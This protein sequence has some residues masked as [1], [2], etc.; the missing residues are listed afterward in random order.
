MPLKRYYRITAGLLLVLLVSAAVFIWFLLT[1]QRRNE[2]FDT[3]EQHQEND[4]LENF[5]ERLFPRKVV[6][7]I[8]NDEAITNN[9]SSTPSMSLVSA[10]PDPSAELTEECMATLDALFTDKKIG[11]L[12]YLWITFKNQLTYGQVYFDPVG[13]RQ[14]VSEAL[15]NPECS[16]GD[17]DE[18]RWDLYEECHADAFARLFHF[19]R[20]CN[21]PSGYADRIDRW[22]LYLWEEQES[23]ELRNQFD[24]RFLAIENA[25]STEQDRLTLQ[26]WEE[27]L[28]IRWVVER[29]EQF[30]VK[31][32]LIDPARDIEIFNKLRAANTKAFV[33]DRH[34]QRM[35]VGE[36]LQVFAARFGEAWAVIT[37]DGTS[38]WHTFRA[39]QYPWIYT[40]R[41]LFRRDAT[42]ASKLLAG[43]QIAI[44]LEESRI[45]F[46]WDYLVS[47]I[48][49]NQLETDSTNC[50]TAINSLRAN[51]DPV[52]SD[53][54]L[55]LG[56]IEEMSIELGVYDQI[57]TDDP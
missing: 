22:F 2:D 31:E 34:G 33:N 35:E 51:L 41:E 6:E 47:H 1:N 48:C 54:L 8:T 28:E 27:V 19:T 3:A 18:P 40:N 16:F 7:P 23:G 43:V 11:H 5:S 26:L 38:S 14:R 15:F 55:V 24:L 25:P 46:D 12:D 10:C 30:N 4:N 37:Y 17:K 56:Q 13:D 49:T 20:K 57:S 9:E 42:R 50:Q 44:E 29:C 32:I 53:K 52:E 45:E 36:S 21:N 39:E